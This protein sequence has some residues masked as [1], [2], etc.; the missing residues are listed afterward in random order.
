MKNIV[1]NE[2]IVQ[3]DTISCDPYLGWIYHQT[4][5]GKVWW[6]PVVK[7]FLNLCNVQSCVYIFGLISPQLN[8]FGCLE[9]LCQDVKLI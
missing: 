8:M 1:K 5:Y 3:R 9:C 6:W 2:L 4:K 7:M